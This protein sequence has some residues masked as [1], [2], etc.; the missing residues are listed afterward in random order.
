MHIISYRK[1]E[2]IE[3]ALKKTNSFESRQ[4][5]LTS[6]LVVCL[7]I[8]MSHWSSDS[9]TTVKIFANSGSPSIKAG[10]DYGSGFSFFP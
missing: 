8:S 2:M 1:P 5:K 10:N 7:A 6:S 9:M 4:R 3:L